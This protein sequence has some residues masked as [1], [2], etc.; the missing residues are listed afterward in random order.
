MNSY[1][2]LRQKAL[3]DGYRCGKEQD[4]SKR[5]VFII[6]ADSVHNG[7]YLCRA[8]NVGLGYAP[9][10]SACAAVIGGAWLRVFHTL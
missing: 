5:E 6:C 2:H 3:V 8:R 4:V 10:N 1:L 9:S 7:I